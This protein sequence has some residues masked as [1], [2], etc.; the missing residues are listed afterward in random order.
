[1]RLSPEPVHS[2]RVHTDHLAPLL[3]PS[4]TAE[5]WLARRARLKS[6]PG[7]WGL[8]LSAELQ[9]L[10]LSG[11]SAE[12]LSARGADF[13]V[14]LWTLG[15]L[16]A[17]GAQ[18]AGEAALSSADWTQL[19]LGATALWLGQA[20]TPPA[21]ETSVLALSPEGQDALP[22]VQAAQQVLAQWSGAE[23]SAL[24]AALMLRW[25]ADPQ[26]V[27]SSAH[28]WRAHARLPRLRPAWWLLSRSESGWLQAHW[29]GVLEAMIQAAAG[30]SQAELGDWTQELAALMGDPRLSLTARTVSHTERQL[31]PYGLRP[32]ELRAERAHPNALVRASARRRDL[33]LTLPAGPWT[34]P[35]GGDW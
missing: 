35:S 17:S 33:G 4:H 21:D 8:R 24:C 6:H 23:L 15:R 20:W 1:M 26:G 2:G 18:R 3:H 29:D 10:A 5:G 9:A 12:M 31:Q 27:M 22:E 14:C 19:A 34:A 30:A 13:G 7:S 32:G 25:G 16:D 28:A 11:A